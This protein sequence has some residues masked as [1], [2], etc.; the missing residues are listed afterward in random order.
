MNTTKQIRELLRTQ[1]YLR[2]D[3]QSLIKQILLI[4]GLSLDDAYLVSKM[5]NYCETVNRTWRYVQ[6]KDANLRGKEWETRQVAG[7]KKAKEVVNGII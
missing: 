1:P 5:F 7:R 6:E 3:N 2:D 4:K